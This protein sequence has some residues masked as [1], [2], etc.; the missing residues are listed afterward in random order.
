MTRW[1][2]I[3]VRPICL[4]KCRQFIFTHLADGDLKVLKSREK[5]VITLDIGAFCARETVLHNSNGAIY[6]SQQLRVLTPHRATFGFAVLVYVGRALFIH[7]YS[8]Q[9]IIDE[10]ARRN[11]LISPRVRLVFRAKSLLLTWP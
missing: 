6:H 4:N 2:G 9:H 11:V 5:K 1:T 3:I 8:E 10:P 7:C